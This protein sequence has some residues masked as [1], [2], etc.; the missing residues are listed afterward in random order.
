MPVYIGKRLLV[1]IPT[2]L[3]I[4]IFVFSLQKL[5]PGDPI[6]A[7]AGEE[8]DP[9]TLAFLREKYH[10]NDPVIMQYFSWL[11]SML[12][13]D[14][15]ISLR[16][17][18]PV[19]ELIGQKLPVTIQLAV[20]A[21]IFALVIG[22]PTG[23]LAAVYKNRAI[24]YIANIVALSGLSVPNFWLGIMLIL[25]ISVQLGWLP[26][27]GYESIFVD[28]VRSIKTM[29]MPAF[30]LSTALAAQLMRHTRSAMLGVLSSDYIRTARAKGLSPR[31]VILSHTFRN[32]LLPIITLSALLFGELLAGAV[33]TEQIFTIPGFGKMTVD[34]VFT[35]D[36]A[37]VQGI[38][39]CTAIGFIVMNLIADV[40]YVLLNPRLRATL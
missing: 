35:R 32:A 14:F 9:A 5:L 16:T 31:E 2:L 24:D 38:V 27:S 30:V 17:N 10:L 4:S 25:L 22:I 28:P 37:V 21:M 36:Y 34:A 18:Q 19:L 15:G 29:I 39:M 7:M 13:G 8:R 11:G 26:A 20:M 33:L 3:I 1:A 6:L 23:I 40:L 12:M